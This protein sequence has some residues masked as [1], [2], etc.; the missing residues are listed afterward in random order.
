MPTRSKTARGNVGTR[1]R[2][3]T[4]PPGDHSAAAPTT[5]DRSRPA[6][7]GITDPRPPSSRHPTCPATRG[8]TDPGP[9]FFTSPYPSI[10]LRLRRLRSGAR[11][12]AAGGS[13]SGGGVRPRAQARGPVSGFPPL[14]LSRRDPPKI[15]FGRRPTSAAFSPPL[16]PFF[17][18]SV[19]PESYC[20]DA[21]GE[22]ETPLVPP[23]SP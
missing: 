23:C 1:E 22:G 9:P 3:S 16:S 21:A 12:R 11:S 13:V 19:S 10:T 6:T 20:P 4:L 8:I 17:G 15:H 7:R 5:D 18:F 2:G 14:S